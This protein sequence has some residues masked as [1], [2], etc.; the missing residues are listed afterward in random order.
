MRGRGFGRGRGGFERG[1]SAATI[2]SRPSTTMLYPPRV[3]YFVPN[4]AS[5]LI[6][7]CAIDSYGSS[8]SNGAATPRPSSLKRGGGGGETLTSS[9]LTQDE[10]WAFLACD[11]LGYNNVMTSPLLPPSTSIRSASL[12]HRSSA[13]HVPRVVHPLATVSCSLELNGDGTVDRRSSRNSRGGGGVRGSVRGVS[14]CGLQALLRQSPNHQAVRALLPP[15]LRVWILPDACN[16]Q[17]L[18]DSERVRLLRIKNGKRP[19]LEKPIRRGGVV[20]PS[21]GSPQR[22]RASGGAAGHAS[23]GAQ[24]GSG[25]LMMGEDEGGVKKPPRSAAQAEGGGGGASDEESDSHSLSSLES[26]MDDDDDG[27]SDAGSN[28]EFTI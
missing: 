6:P 2:N 14:A 15:E 21:S 5:H 11:S 26:A 8:S 20:L 10:D 25:G 4:D 13:L 19:R 12:G 23:A 22:A 24:D 17:P 3:S 7:S 9:L 28:N 27:F 16:P 1:Q 18:S